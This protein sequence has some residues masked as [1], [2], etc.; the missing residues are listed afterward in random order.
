MD[1]LDLLMCVVP[2]YD[3]GVPGN[4]TFI[5]NGI[6]KQSGFT[7]KVIDFNYSISQQFETVFDGDVD[8][9]INADVLFDDEDPKALEYPKFHTMIDQ[10][11]DII[12]KEN[13]RYVGF[14]VLTYLN[15]I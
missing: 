11:V 13:P 9:W 5:I 4:S 8:D 2:H 7:S 15:Y 6:A 1:K 10:W 14:S 12:I 3:A